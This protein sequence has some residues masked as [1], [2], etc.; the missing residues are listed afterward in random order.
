MNLWPARLHHLRRDSPQ[1]S[2][3][4]FYGELLGDR[5]E[6][7]G[8][9]AWGGGRPPPPPG[10][11]PRHRGRG[12]YFA[13]Q[14]QDAAHLR[15]YAREIEQRGLRREASPT[16]LFADG[17]ARSRI[18][19]DAASSSDCLKNLRRKTPARAAA[20]FVCATNRLP[21]MVKFYGISHDRIRSST[22]K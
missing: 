12:P 10:D 7:L 5:V 15:A 16:P 13:L 3:C 9:D 17:A 14:M 21:E 4:K 11:R 18:R 2:A 22:R 19:T 6:R 20:A 8:E 1:P